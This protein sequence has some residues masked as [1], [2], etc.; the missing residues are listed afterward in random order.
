MYH[1]L[2]CLNAQ[3]IIQ[4]AKYDSKPVPPVAAKKRRPAER[5]KSRLFVSKEKTDEAKKTS[6]AY[7]FF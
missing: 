1:S 2:L 7:L 3:K 5:E 4:L 6:S